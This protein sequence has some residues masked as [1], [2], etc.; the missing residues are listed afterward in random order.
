MSTAI[1]VSP[2]ENQWRW[3]GKL[4]LCM[5]HWNFCVRSLDHSSRRRVN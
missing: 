3:Q 4:Q 5:S 1:L 2:L